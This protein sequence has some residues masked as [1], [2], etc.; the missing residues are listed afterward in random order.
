MAENIIKP[1]WAGE[2]V[3]SLFLY[4]ITQKELADKVGITNRY[5]CMLLSGSR[6]NAKTEKKI[7]SILN[8]MISEKNMNVR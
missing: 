5:L 6:S 8:D 7:M 4:N 3:K 1:E 2:V